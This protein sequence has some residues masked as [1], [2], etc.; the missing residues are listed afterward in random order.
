MLN[1]SGIPAI[2]L[3]I[4]IFSCGGDNSGD[5]KI[6]IKLNSLKAES[7]NAVGVMRSSVIPTDVET[8]EIR[9]FNAESS[10][11]YYK[12]SF[13]AENLS[14][15]SSLTIE[16][17]PGGDRIVKAIGRSSTGLAKYSGQSESMDLHD[18]E[19]I[20][21]TLVMKSVLQD[22]IIPVKLLDE[23]GTGD[24]YTIPSYASSIKAEVY[25]PAA[26]SGKLELGS[27]LS[28]NYSGNAIT[29]N[30]SAY[31]D[32]YQMIMVRVMTKD[33]E[34][35]APDGVIAAIGSEMVSELVSGN[36]NQIVIRMVKPG[37][38][39]VT[40]SSGAPITSYSVTETING[41]DYVI[42]S[43]S[44]LTGGNTILLTVPNGVPVWGSEYDAVTNPGGVRAISRTVKININGGST[45][46]YL[47]DGKV[48]PYLRWK[49]IDLNY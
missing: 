28:G 38:L 13:T 11:I 35:V 48:Y 20:S 2:A 22:A 30:L 5:S 40:N 29:F 44:S 16:V 19:S 41:S 34:D 33:I 18:E 6:T 27:S 8:I 1:K 37:R 17:K 47:L 43:G 14:P 10:E 46:T 39:Y 4:F 23:N 32:T 25:I 42:S 3:L 15:T 45:N 21:V 31:P 12:K 26:V 7:D 24:E 9:V 49:Q 36:N